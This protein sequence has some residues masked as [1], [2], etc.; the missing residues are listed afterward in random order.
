MTIELPDVPA[1]DRLTPDEIR[2]ELA[3]A[4][5]ARGRIGKVA[6]TQMAGVDFFTFQRALSERRVPLYTEQMLASDLQSL[7]ETFSK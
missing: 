6:A 4:L 3:C 7:N 2:L 1:A 5:Y